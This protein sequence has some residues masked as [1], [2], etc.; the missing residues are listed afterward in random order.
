MKAQRRQLMWHGMLVFLLGLITGL[1]EQR[2]TN[3][4]M[5]LSAYLQSVI[6]GILLPALGA[7]WNEARVPHPVKVMAYCTALYG[8][9]VNWL[10]T[11]IGAAFGAAA[12]SPNSRFPRPPRTCAHLTL[13]FPRIE[14]DHAG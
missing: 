13:H 8:T 10:V 4:R 14:Q 6:S 12:S 2:F 3:V 9:Y 1:F 7:G 11:S 5:G